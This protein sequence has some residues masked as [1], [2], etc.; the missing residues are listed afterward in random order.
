MDVGLALSAVHEEA[1]LA[2][3]SQ[4]HVCAWSYSFCRPAFKGKRLG[5]ASSKRKFR[6]VNASPRPTLPDLFAKHGLL[7][8][9]LVP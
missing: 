9:L 2:E 6:C 8:L 1:L 4:G 5:Q 7:E 3:R